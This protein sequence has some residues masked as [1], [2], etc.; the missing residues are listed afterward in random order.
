MPGLASRGKSN[1]V[2]DFVGFNI[3]A[4]RYSALT[5]LHEF[6]RV[7]QSAGAMLS[8]H[9][10]CYLAVLRD[11]SKLTIMRSIARRVVGVLLAV[12]LTACTLELPSPVSASVER[13]MNGA[14]VK[15]W[16]LTGKQTG[17]LAEWFKQ[18]QSGWSPSYASYAPRLLVR[19]KHAGGK[20]SSVNVLPSGLIVLSSN[21]GQFT[22]S[23]EAKVVG[24][25]VAAVEGNDG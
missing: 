19:V 12:A 11:I 5:Q 14:P 6:K 21:E 13:Y 17:S 2:G 16:A 3:P 18:H 10:P 1:R 20:E 22:Q 24:E 4:H 7:F 8:D 9:P 23:F 25:L 15:T